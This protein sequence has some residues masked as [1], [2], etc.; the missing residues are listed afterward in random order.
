MTSIAQQQHACDSYDAIDFRKGAPVLAKAKAEVSAA[1]TLRK[2]TICIDCSG[3]LSATIFKPSL[4]GPNR[5]IP[6]TALSLEPQRK[7]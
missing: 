4:H 6:P 2:K 7:G 3:L 1:E 5:W